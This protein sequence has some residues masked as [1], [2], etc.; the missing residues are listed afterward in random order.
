[1]RIAL[2]DLLEYEI[3]EETYAEAEHDEKQCADN[4][5]G[6]LCLGVLEADNESQHDYADNIVDYCA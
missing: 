2:V 3:S 1:M 6:G 5:L 4:D